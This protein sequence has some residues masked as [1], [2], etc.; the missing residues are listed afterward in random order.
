ME[1]LHWQL[2]G[3][4]FISAVEGGSEVAQTTFLEP[5]SQVTKK[6]I[7]LVP[8]LKKEELKMKRKCLLN[9]VVIV[10][11]KDMMRHTVG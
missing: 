5:V 7:K 8:V 9:H 4:R 2:Y 3:S 1:C 6:H 10:T 11:R